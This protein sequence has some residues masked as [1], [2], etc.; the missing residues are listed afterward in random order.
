MSYPILKL[1]HASDHDHVTQ[2]QS[3]LNVVRPHLQIEE[4][5]VTGIFDKAT[6]QAV[7]AFQVRW[8]LHKQDGIVG[9]ET[10]GA[11]WE[12][13]RERQNEQQHQDEVDEYHRSLQQPAA[14][15]PAADPPPTLAEVDHARELLHYY[16][17][18][19]VRRATPFAE[20][21]LDLGGWGEVAPKLLDLAHNSV[22]LAEVM[23][24]AGGATAAAGAEAAA[25]DAAIAGG[26]DA[27]VTAGAA[28]GLLV[29][30]ST[31]L[32][33][34]GPL[35]MWYEAIGAN[36]AGELHRIR[37]HVYHAFKAGFWPGLYG[38]GPLD[39]EQLFATVINTANQHSNAFSDAQKRGCRAILLGLGN[40]AVPIPDATNPTMSAEHWALSGPSMNWTWD[41][42]ENLITHRDR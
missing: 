13:V 10:W 4:L 12:A 37:W 17:D 22:L 36:D 7:V 21:I 30:G 9:D 26:A 39:G 28:E 41:G 42:L 5:P 3:M 38:Q 20:K 11:L 1:G 25:A 27:A 40:S 23:H 8:R 33:I 15:Q 14:Q 18:D 31:L 24:G 6:E 34:V 2:V 16:V 29:A 35:A 32:T 19:I